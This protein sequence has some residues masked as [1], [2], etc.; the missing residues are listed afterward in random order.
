MRDLLNDTKKNKKIAKALR[1]KFVFLNVYCRSVKD[2]HDPRGP[3]GP[4]QFKDRSVPVVVI[5]KFDGT[6]LKQQLGWGGGANRLAHIVD[7]AVKDNGPVA[8]PKALRPLLKSFA[9]AQK[10]LDRKQVRTA[11]RELQNV[12]KGGQNQKK[13]KDG[14]PD[15]ALKAQEELDKLK[16]AGMQQLEAIRTKIEDGEQDVAASKK[17]L[18]RLMFAYGG[19]AE[20]KAK[21]KAALQEL[22]GR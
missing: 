1:E 12:V 13:F 15:V 16:S 22:D 9:K 19:I 8:P 17:A 10:A 3:K 11:V 2:E 18:N 21:V 7:R 14:M 20:V 5:K 4:Y 6:T